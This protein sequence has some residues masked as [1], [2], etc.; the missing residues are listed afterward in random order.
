MV[1]V[2]S[3]KVERYLGR[4]RRY[5]AGS[6]LVEPALALTAQTEAPPTI[7]L[8]Y[9]RGTLE[10]PLTVYYTIDINIKYLALTT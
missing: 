6:S 4:G 8:I 5:I 2:Y 10:T 1:F 3:N 9:T 7:I